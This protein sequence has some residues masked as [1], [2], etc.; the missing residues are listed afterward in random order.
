MIYEKEKRYII[1]FD[2]VPTPRAKMPEISIEERKGNFKEVELGFPEDVAMAE[3]KRCLSCRRCLGC[4]LCWA[5]CKPE[6]IDFSMSDEELMLEF[7]EIII[8][9]GH[10]NAFHP[11]KEELGYGRYANVITDLQLERM[12]S[13]TG[14]TDGII[15]SPL[16]GDIPKNIAFVQSY[17]NADESHL[18]SSVIYGINEA[19]LALDKIN[20]LQVILISPL[21]DEFKE[22]HLSQIKDMP[23]LKIIDGVPE[24]VK[25]ENK[26][27]IVT[28]SVNGKKESLSSVDLVVILTR[29]RPSDY[30]KS[31]SRWLE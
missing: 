24:S 1:P 15:M 19:I 21:C 22:N 13:E 17:P 6:A 27:L 4:A 9:N 10:D 7:D 16:N 26:G 18:L 2:D 11:I 29:S 20:D 12:L 25:E 3:A 14:P 5:E 8:T 31:I 30:V 28:W 23:A